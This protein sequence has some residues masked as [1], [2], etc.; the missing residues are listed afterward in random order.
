MWHKMAQTPA[1]ETWSSLRGS[2]LKPVR[3]RGSKQVWAKP[4]DIWFHLTLFT[5]TCTH[6]LSLVGVKWI[7]RVPV[8]SGF[9]DSTR[10]SK[11]LFVTR[12]FEN[13]KAMTPN[14]RNKNICEIMWHNMA[15]THA[16]ETYS[17]NWQEGRMRVGT[18][19]CIQ[20]DVP[21]L[22]FSCYK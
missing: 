7:P 11:S 18:F 14:Y 15:L 5:A 22:A 9:I 20:G 19:D 4:I 8:G 10:S 6:L 2:K 21:K 17:L 1:I 3:S 16:I 13:Y 12:G